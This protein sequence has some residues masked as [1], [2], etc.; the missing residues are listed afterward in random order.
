MTDRYIRADAES[1]QVGWELG[2]SARETHTG[3]TGAVRRRVTNRGQVCHSA[4]FASHHGQLRAVV[5]HVIDA[6]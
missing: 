6:T 1:P 3:V 4:R 2:L 5:T